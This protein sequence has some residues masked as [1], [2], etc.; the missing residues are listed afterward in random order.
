MSRARLPNR[1][2]ARMLK[3]PFGGMSYFVSYALG[4]GGSVAEV[5]ISCDR[6]TSDA[7]QVARD[8]AVTISIALQYGAALDVMR[9]AIT[10][11]HDGVA[12][13]IIGAA[14]DS[15][16]GDEGPDGVGGPPN[17]KGGLPMTGGAVFSDADAA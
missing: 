13:S 15:I 4:A 16:A 6:P 9:G 1:R 17:P 2:P 8:A 12:A 14:L 5:F 11:D 7:A 3:I 10:R